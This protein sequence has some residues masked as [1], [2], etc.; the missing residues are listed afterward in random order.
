MEVDNARNKE[1]LDTLHNRV[2]SISSIIKFLADEG[3]T[4]NTKILTILKW[5]SLLIHAFENID[6][7]DGEQKAKIEELYNKVITL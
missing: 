3:Y 5:S 1:V 2:S 4:P 6:I 7:F